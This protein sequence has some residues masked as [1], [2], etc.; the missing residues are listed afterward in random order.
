[1]ETIEK[2]SNRYSVRW[3]NEIG[4]HLKQDGGDGNSQS[5]PA[6]WTFGTVIWYCFVAFLIYVTVG[7]AFNYIIRQERSFPELFPHHRF[8]VHF[9]YILLVF[10]QLMQDI[11]DWFKNRLRGNS[12]YVSL[13]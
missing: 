4:C 7:I 11:F 8:W 9:L 6:P 13:G 10:L 2:S 5:K 12:Q 1:M 3:E